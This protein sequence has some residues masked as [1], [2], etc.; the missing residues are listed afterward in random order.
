MPNRHPPKRRLPR[1]DPERRVHT[2]R[3]RWRRPITRFVGLHGSVG[4]VTIAALSSAS[5]FRT[6]SRGRH[7]RQPASHTV[8][9]ALKRRTGYVGEPA[10]G[11]GKVLR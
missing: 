2:S 4:P 11:A 3:C 5:R 9:H 7:V 8:K 10:A 1:R 6:S